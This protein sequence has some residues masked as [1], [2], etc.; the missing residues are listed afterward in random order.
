M[1]ASTPQLLRAARRNAVRIALVDMVLNVALVAVGLR[2][3]SELLV[4]VGAACFGFVLGATL[5]A[6]G[7]A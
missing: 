2:T 4:I 7:V 3:G 1:T 5:M 6:H